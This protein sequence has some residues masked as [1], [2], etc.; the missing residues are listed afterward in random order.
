MTSTTPYIQVSPQESAEQKEALFHEILC[1]VG[2][3]GWSEGT[4]AQAAISLGKDPAWTRALF[5]GGIRDVL[6]TW[7]MVSMV[8]MRTQAGGLDLPSMKVR[9]R[10]FWLVR[11]HLGALSSYPDAAS[12]SLKFLLRPREVPFGMHLLYD[13]ID[14]MWRLA[15]DESTDY[16]FYTKRL[17]LAG[18]YLS[19]LLFWLR[20]TSPEKY[21]TWSFLER[22]IENVLSLGTIKQ[23]LGDAQAWVVKTAQVLLKRFSGL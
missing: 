15:G 4:L 16:N 10:I 12:T 13:L 8:A 14:D 22:H 9:E 7:A 19:T 2:Q 20:D 6:Q 17:L 21:K 23:E 11:L 1:L 5:P 3:D 18:V